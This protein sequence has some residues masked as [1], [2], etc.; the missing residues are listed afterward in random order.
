M[1]LFDTFRYIRPSVRYFVHSSVGLRFV[2][3]IHSLKTFFKCIFFYPVVELSFVNR[4]QR[5]SAIPHRNRWWLTIKKKV[6]LEIY[7]ARLGY[8]RA[9]IS[10]IINHAS[11]YIYLFVVWIKWGNLR[12]TFRFVYINFLTGCN[13]WPKNREI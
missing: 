12:K 4:T 11:V 3:P 8:I 2:I 1:I 7:L 13:I 9:I 10:I 6:T 5:P